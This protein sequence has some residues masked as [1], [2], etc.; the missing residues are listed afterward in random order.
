MNNHYI[1]GFFNILFNYLTYNYLEQFEKLNCKC[2]INVKRDISKVM[3]LTFYVIIFGKIFYP[4]LP[5]TAQLAT[6]IYTLIFD[7]V[8]VSY[9]FEL[10]ESKCSCDDILQDTTTAII[11]TYYILLTFIIISSILMFLLS[12]ML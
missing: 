9:I 6:I 11:Y 12:I 7:L 4:D 1:I 8:F 2:S 3:L 5:K 10:K